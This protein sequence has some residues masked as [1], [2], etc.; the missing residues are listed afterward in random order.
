MGVD[1]HHRKPDCLAG[2]GA[3]SKKGWDWLEQ[4]SNPRKQ[5][6]EG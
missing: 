2:V 3:N 6:K 1:R 4:G 5:E